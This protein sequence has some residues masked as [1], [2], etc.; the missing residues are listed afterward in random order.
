MACNL[1]GSSC[2][3]P[4]LYGELLRKREIVCHHFCLLFSQ[5]L[6]QN[7]SDH[8]GLQGFKLP[9]IR[10]EI[11]KSARKVCHFCQRRGA[12][13]RCHAPECSKKFHVSCAVHAGALLSFFGRFE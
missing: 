13:S 7:G 12:H 9:D 10:K 3:A 5:G 2:D 8:E 1:C 4:L 6:P 11:K